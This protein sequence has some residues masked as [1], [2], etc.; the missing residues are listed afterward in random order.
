METIH[1]YLAHYGYLG[2]F[3]WLALG[4]FGPP[5]ADEL[6]LLFLGYLA[7]KGETGIIP[8]VVVVAG[9]SLTGVTLDYLLGRT[10]GHYLLHRPNCWLHRQYRQV[11]QLQQW[12]AR[13]GG[14]VYT[15]SYFVPGW[16]HCAPMVAGLS[17]LNFPRFAAWTYSGGLLWT[18]GY[19]LLGYLLGEKWS[20]DLLQMHHWLILGGVGLSVGLAYKILRKKAAGICQIP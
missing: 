10:V 17:A 14:W 3:L 19:L 8:T 2:V 7:V 18:L 6:L 1:Y 20:G 13:W 16:R 15:C 5:V 12:L 4:I 9:G 11:Y